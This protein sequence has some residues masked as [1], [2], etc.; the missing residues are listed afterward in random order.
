MKI[1]IALLFALCIPAYGQAVR[2]LDGNATNLNV[3]QSAPIRLHFTIHDST[4]AG[5]AHS[6]EVTNSAIANSWL[7]Y[8]DLGTWYFPTV[9]TTN[10]LTIFD[11]LL[12]NNNKQIRFKDSGGTYRQIIGVSGADN[13]TIQGP[14]AGS[15][16]MVGP[17][18]VASMTIKSTAP[19][20]SLYM[21]A[22][23][24]GIGG[25]TDPQAT[26]DVNTGL[27]SSNAYF[28][29]IHLRTNSHPSESVI[30]LTNSFA[31]FAT[32]NNTFFDNLAGIS[33]ARTNMQS[34]MVTMTNSSAAVKTIT[35]NARFQ[36]MN[37]ADGNTLFL[38]NVGQLLVYF[39]PG[40]G[41]NFYFKSR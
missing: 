22:G 37:A 38:T 23:G 11:N 32:N 12:M 15:D 8:N 17:F 14:S 20:N 28:T 1:P 5:N 13:L 35:M 16:L 18:G 19:L 40:F 4:T 26:L 2:N 6:F 39:Y 31:A 9:V 27:R 29:T 25:I 21:V 3:W 10:N 34:V 24:V 30:S 33:T 41:T 36:N 7:G